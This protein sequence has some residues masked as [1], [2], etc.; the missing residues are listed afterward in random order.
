[1]VLVVV[2]IALLVVGATPWLILAVA[3]VGLICT[4][5]WVRDDRRMQRAAR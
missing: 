5:L 2:F 1:M 3:A 4:G